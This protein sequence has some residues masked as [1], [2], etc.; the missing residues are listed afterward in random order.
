MPKLLKKNGRKALLGRGPGHHG[1]GNVGAVAAGVGAIEGNLVRA[2]KELF[3]KARGG[4]R[5]PAD[6]K[7]RSRMSWLNLCLPELWVAEPC[8]DCLL[9]P[10]LNREPQDPRVDTA[11]QDSLP[12]FLFWKCSSDAY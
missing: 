9:S 3:L 11:I 7:L 8:R 5:K 1:R 6:R 4:L 12:E 10:R 2:G